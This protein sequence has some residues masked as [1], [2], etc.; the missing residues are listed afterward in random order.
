MLDERYEPAPIEREPTLNE[1]VDLAMRRMAAALVIAGGV[2]ALAIYVRPGPPRYDAIATPTG[3]VRIDT[4]SGK[5]IACE[6]GRCM[7]VL[8][9]HQRLAP[10]PNVLKKPKPAPALP[11][12]KQ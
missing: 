5:M 7:T 1:I 12:P 4:R 8:E 10:N 11:A 3:I 9:R 6:G 2:I